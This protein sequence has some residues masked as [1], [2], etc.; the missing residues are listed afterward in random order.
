MLVDASVC[1]DVVDGLIEVML[2][3]MLTNDDVSRST[4]VANQSHCNM[5][6]NL[7]NMLVVKFLT[8]GRLQHLSFVQYN[9]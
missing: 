5:Q 9:Y 1:V 2:M 7:Y 6:C 8:V 4:R 3:S